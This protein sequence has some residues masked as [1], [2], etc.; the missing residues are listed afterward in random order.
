MK[1][2]QEQLRFSDAM[3][4][5]GFRWRNGAWCKDAWMSVDDVKSA[6]QGIGRVNADRWHGCEPHALRLVGIDTRRRDAN[7]VDVTYRLEYRSAKPGL[8]TFDPG[9]AQLTAARVY[10]E[11]A[12]HDAIP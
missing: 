3:R 4:A 8:L 1:P 12:F 5:A 11:T 2:W 6:L 10:G 7:T 9:P